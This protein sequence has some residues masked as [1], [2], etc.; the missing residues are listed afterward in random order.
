MELEQKLLQNRQNKIFRNEGDIMNKK[1]VPNYNF[2]YSK[3]ETKEICKLNLK[4]VK[5]LETYVFD[6][7]KNGV[8]TIDCKDL[9]KTGAFVTEEIKIEL[10]ND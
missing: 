9:F 5:E 10:L 4:N 1:N 8:I 6:A 2:G 3:E 7:I